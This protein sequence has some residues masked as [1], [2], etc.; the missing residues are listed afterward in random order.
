M[1]TTS[2]SRPSPRE[3]LAAMTEERILEGVAALLRRGEEVTFDLAAR[4]SGVP[5]RTLYRYFEN[6]EALFCAFWQWTNR[7]IEMPAPPTTPAE[8]VSHIL[9]LYA[10]F[11]RDEPLVR[12]MLHN[13]Y[14]RAVRLAHAEAR[15]KKFTEALREVIAPLPETAATRVLATITVIASA[16]GWETMKDNWQLSGNAAAEAAQWAAETLIDDARK[17]ACVSLR[18]AR[19][20]ER[21][22]VTTGDHPS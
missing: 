12:A 16:T 19:A 6:K 18:D 20:E 8:V 3:E 11:D 22:D 21:R 2:S 1:N 13:P 4:E 9:G 10:A 7:Q 14:G 15:R 17:Q 5:Q